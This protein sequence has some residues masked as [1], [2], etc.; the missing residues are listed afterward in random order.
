MNEN[1]KHIVVDEL[2]SLK[3]RII[4]N[5][6]SS[7]Q[8]AS[9]QTIQSLNIVENENGATLFGRFPFGTL[10]TGRK[11]GRVPKNFQAIILQWM[12]DKGIQS[13][14]ITYLR[15]PSEKWQPKYTPQQRGDFSLSG[16]ISYK[17]MTEGTTL[18]RKGGRKD[19]HSNEIPT[20]IGNIK[21]K[22]LSF[23]ITEINS[24]KTN[25]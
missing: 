18:Y 4:A 2:N 9:G 17:I 24:I 1:I 20:T 21:N 15:K 25:N 10:E 3:Q 19:V 7:G 6:T 16:A 11:A 13:T 14:P 22:L 5:I 8:N 12:K 23:Y